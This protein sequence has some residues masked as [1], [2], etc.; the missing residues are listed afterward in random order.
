MIAMRLGE[1]L[2]GKGVITAAQVE[3]AME[4]QRRDGGRLG[5]HLVAIGALTV[6]QLLN[7]LRA[8]QEAENTLSLCRHALERSERT[9]GA[10]HAN[11]DRARYNLAR[12]LLMAGYATDAVPYAEAALDGHRFMLGQGHAWTQ[13]AAQLVAN[14]CAAAARAACGADE[15]EMAAALL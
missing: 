2:V 12:A 5:N 11:T 6:D 13:D 1:L 10:A 14:V 7:T 8:Q 9:Y 4:R 3:A 15:S